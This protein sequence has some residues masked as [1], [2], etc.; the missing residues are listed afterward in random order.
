MI[1]TSPSQ[2]LLVYCYFVP[3]VL[4][5]FYILQISEII[6]QTNFINFLGYSLNCYRKTLKYDVLN[7]TEEFSLLANSLKAS[8]LSRAGVSHASQSHSGP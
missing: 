8:G 6:R 5:C 4:F 2:C 1:T 7:E 3:F